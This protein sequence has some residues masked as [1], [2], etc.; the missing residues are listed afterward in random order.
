MNLLTNGLRVQEVDH[1][2]RLMKSGILPVEEY[3]KVFRPRHVDV[4][5]A[6]QMW[7]R[8]RK[9]NLWLLRGWRFRLYCKIAYK[10]F[11]P[12]LWR[13]MEVHG[14][15]SVWELFGYTEDEICK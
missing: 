6:L 15:S 7:F 2:T 5:V 11:Y 10:W 13:L 12:F 9:N 8:W 14:C 3:K 4:R 1:L